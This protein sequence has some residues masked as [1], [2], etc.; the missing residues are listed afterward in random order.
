MS[1]LFLAAALSTSTPS[2]DGGEDG[3]QIIHTD[4]LEHMLRQG[5][6]QVHL[7]DANNDEFRKKEG[8][9]P[10]AVLLEGHDFDV[11][12]VLP[13]DKSATLVFYCSNRL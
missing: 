7:Y 4:Q 3:F 1:F 13:A 2:S 5:K 8:I 6:P 9:I 11:Q 12:K 10:G